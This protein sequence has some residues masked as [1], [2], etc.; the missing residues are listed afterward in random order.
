VL[1]ALTG[2]SEKPSSK[3]S[4]SVQDSLYTEMTQFAKDIASHFSYRAIIN[5]DSSDLAVFLNTHP[6]FNT[7]RKDIFKF[8][9]NRQF[10][11]A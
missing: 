5:F 1:Y 4:T 9:S 6:V 10:S 2:C 11:Y 3:N 8:Y 7:Y